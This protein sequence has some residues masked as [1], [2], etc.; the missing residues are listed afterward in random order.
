MDW[1]QSLLWNIK[2][3]QRLAELG[4]RRVTVHLNWTAPE[5]RSILVEQRQL[6]RPSKEEDKMKGLTKRGPNSLFAVGHSGDQ[7]QSQHPRG[8]GAPCHWGMSWAGAPRHLIVDLDSAFKDN[9]LQVMN[10]T[11][12]IVRCAAGQAHWQ[13]G[14][15]E[16]RGG[17]WKEIKSGTSWLKITQSSPPGPPRCLKQ[18]L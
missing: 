15:A 4:E 12:V 7:E 11:A 10:E 18:W 16:R 2:K 5:L 9:F 13:N 17:A 6:E 1:P 14:I 3:L 8:L